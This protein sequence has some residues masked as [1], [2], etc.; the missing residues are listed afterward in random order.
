VDVA[1]LGGGGGGRPDRLGPRRGIVVS[2][3]G[4]IQRVKAVAS[5]TARDGERTFSPGVRTCLLKR[6]RACGGAWLTR[7]EASDYISYVDV[8]H[9]AIP[10]GRPLP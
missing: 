4:A 9:P 8:T 5:V 3:A 2:F 1:P 7:A 6:K 10:R